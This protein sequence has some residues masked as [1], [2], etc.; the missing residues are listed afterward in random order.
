MLFAAQ[1]ISEAVIKEQT[2]GLEASETT[3]EEHLQEKAQQEMAMENPEEIFETPAPDAI[4]FEDGSSEEPD[5]QVASASEEFVNDLLP[6]DEEEKLYEK[7]LALDPVLMLRGNPIEEMSETSRKEKLRGRIIPEKR[8]ISRRRYMFRWVLQTD[9]GR[10]IPLKSNLKLLTL[11]RKEELLDG[12]AMLTGYFVA[13]ALNPELKY[14]NVEN[15]V[16]AG[17]ADEGKSEKSAV[18]KDK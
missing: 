3:L 14:F 6:E 11:V 10:R 12:P 16:P 15:A 9:D 2:A 17:D 4:P 18:K 5:L 1:D 8:N 7:A 13:S